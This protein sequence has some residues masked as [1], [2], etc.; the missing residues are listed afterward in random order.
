MATTATSSAPGNGECPFTERPS[1]R[2]SYLANASQKQIT[3]EKKTRSEGSTDSDTDN[4]DTND[5]EGPDIDWYPS[6]EGYLARV[7]RL[8]KSRHT[9]PTTLPQGYP[10]AVK[11]ERAW[12]GSDLADKSYLYLLSEAEVKEIEA[13]LNHFKGSC[14]LHIHT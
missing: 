8:S 2:A 4:S 12:T 13:A 9:R 6:L 10:E 3:Q 14:P 7:D 1:L 11:T 5:E